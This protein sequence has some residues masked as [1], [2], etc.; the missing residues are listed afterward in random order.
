[1]RREQKV[2]LGCLALVYPIICI[3]VY[4]LKAGTPEKQEFLG[5]EVN[6]SL[7]KGFANWLF[8]HLVSLPLAEV[9]MLVAIGL[10]YWVIK[11]NW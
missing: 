9:C 10:F 1:M 6:M 4:G 3:I 5:S 7:Q 2:A 11:E 8:N